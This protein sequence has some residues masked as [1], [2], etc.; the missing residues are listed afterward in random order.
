MIDH[1]RMAFV[2][3]LKTKDEVP[4]VFKHFFKY[5]DTQCNTKLKTIRSDNEWARV[6]QQGGKQHSEPG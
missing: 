5:L 2:Y 3:F 4:K 1:S 6:C